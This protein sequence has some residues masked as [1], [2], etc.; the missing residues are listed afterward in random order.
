M[1]KKL[2]FKI[3]SFFDAVKDFLFQWGIKILVI[4]IGLL[5]LHNALKIVDLASVGYTGQ[6]KNLQEVYPEDEKYANCYV[7]GEGSKTV[8]ILP[9]FGES[10]P[11]IEY[12][13][14]VR[15]LSDEYRVAVIEGFGYGYSM[16]M[17]KYPRTNENICAEIM[18]MLDLSG[19]GGPYVF[20]AHGQ[21]SIYAMYLAEHYPDYVSGVILLDSFYPK[22]LE[23]DYRL[24]KVKDQVANYNYT[25]IFELTGYERIVSYIHPETFKIDH[26]RTIPEIYGEEEIKQYRDR[27]AMSYLSRTMMREINKMQDNARQVMDYKFSAYL[28]SLQIISSEKEEEFKK[29]YDSKKSN[30]NSDILSNELITNP[31]IQRV[32]VIEGDHDLEFSNPKGVIEEV[33][34]FLSTF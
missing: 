27:I 22:E 34:A 29:D 26:M 20:M 17:R 2:L 14:L 5:V 15:G 10:S 30:T 8:V 11:V 33:K 32:T 3:F 12:Q 9:G 1:I 23:D 21:S 28:P 18:K 13:T 24:Q 25:S 7:T 6:Y 4:L 31:L 19:I 16:S